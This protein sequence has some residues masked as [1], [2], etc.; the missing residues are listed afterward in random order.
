MLQSRTPSCIFLDTYIT[1]T[2]A[3]VWIICVKCNIRTLYEH[4]HVTCYFVSF[5]NNLFFIF[6]NIIYSHR[7][8]QASLLLQIFIFIQMKIFIIFHF[9][10][11][12]L[13]FYF[14]NNYIVSFVGFKC[15]HAKL[16]LHILSIVPQLILILLLSSSYFFHHKFYYI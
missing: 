14:I 9:I 4:N 5:F 10:I 3:P 6:W 1:W 2:K 16:L 8:T 13:T 7:S 15:V 11:H 12:I